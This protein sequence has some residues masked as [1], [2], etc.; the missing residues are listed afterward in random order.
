M[1]CQLMIEYFFLLTYLSVMIY[2]YVGTYSIY[3]NILDETLKTPINLYIGLMPH[4]FVRSY[5]KFISSRC[6]QDC[7]KE[8]SSSMLTTTLKRGS[9]LFLFFYVLHIHVYITIFNFPQQLFRYMTKWFV[10]GPFL[11]LGRQQSN[12]NQTS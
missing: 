12:Q 1:K 3:V 11:D 5:R 6:D 2:L 9:V 7:S 8:N 10:H 4:S